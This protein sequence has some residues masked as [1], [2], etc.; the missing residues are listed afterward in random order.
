MTNT[1]TFPR[2]KK[3]LIYGKSVEL[4]QFKP[5]EI[6]QI[7]IGCNSSDNEE[8]PMKILK[9]AYSENMVSEEFLNQ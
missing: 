1:T 2:T 3:F 4:I 8:L 7:R 6:V 9:Y 5:G